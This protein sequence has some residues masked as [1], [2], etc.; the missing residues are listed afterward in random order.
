MEKNLFREHDPV[1]F[2][3]KNGQVD[4]FVK[5]IRANYSRVVTLSGLEYKVHLRFLR[6]RPNVAPRR[7]LSSN[8]EARLTFELD[9]AVSFTSKDGKSLSGRIT[10]LNR[11]RAKVA[12][13]GA[14]WDVPYVHLKNDS[15]SSNGQ[16]NLAR[17]SAVE[18]EAMALLSKH[19]LHDWRFTFDHANRRGGL[20]SYTA[21]VISMSE[22]FVLHADNAEVTD[23]ILHEIAHAL[24]GPNH[25]HDKVWQQTAK[26]IGCTGNRTHDVKFSKARWLIKCTQCDWQVPR[27][28]KTRGLVCKTCRSPLIYVPNTA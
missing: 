15:D 27:H 14:T 8:D 24:V 11:S 16:T 18:S 3:T 21:Q 28:K 1:L 13:N 9:N 5:S 23:T 4:G 22:R 19:G 12:V 6:H 26:Q 7:V 20:C 17:L 2:K 25:G 10:K